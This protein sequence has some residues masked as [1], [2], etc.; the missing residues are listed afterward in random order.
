MYNIASTLGRTTK[1]RILLCADVILV[2][3]ALLAAIELQYEEG[4]APENIAQH[5]LA[6]PLLMGLGGLLTM[7]LGLHRV[8]LKAF[9][10]HAIGM[11]ALH[12]IL[13]GLATAVI[14][15]IA[16]YGTSLATFINFALLYF[17]MAF[18]TRMVMLQGLLAIYRHEQPQ[19]R[20]LIYGAGQTGRQLAA[21]L[22]TDQSTALVAFVDDNETLQ[23]TLVQGLTI[24]SPLT[25]EA[26]VKAR[27]IDRVVLAMP[28]M[29][30]AKQAQISR[31][32]RELGVDVHTVPSFAQ[33]TGQ[34]PVMQQMEPAPTDSLLGR[35]ALDDALSGDTETYA[36]KVVLISGAGGSIGS[37]LCRQV[38]SHKPSCIVLF[39]ISELALYTI[40]MELRSLR[41]N[42]KIVIV[43][44]LGSVTDADL[45]AR[46]LANCNVQIVLH[47]AAYKHVTLVEQNPIAGMSNNVLG[48]HTL[49]RAAATAQIERFILVSTDKAVRPTNIMGAS[50]RLAEMLVHDL[51]NNAKGRTIFCMVRFGNVIGSS[52]SVIPLFHEQIKLGGPVTVTHPDVTRYFMTISEAARLVLVA[53]SFDASG[54][55]FVLDMGEPVRIFDLACQMIDAV[56]Y[57]LRNEANPDG[58][59]EI[60]IIGLQPGEKI[61]EELLIGKGQTTTAHPKILQANEKHLSEIEVASA[62]RAVKDAIDRAD[63][64]ALRAVIAR[65]VEGGTDFTQSARKTPNL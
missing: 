21:A 31:R 57:S 49:A 52:G 58:D 43:P 51:A 56:G 30:H 42:K 9:E 25:L 22:R 63:E 17:F 27:K 38:A 19:C 14:D 35:P 40:D 4:I 37:E 11:T 2:A 15:D 64:P 65:W 3:P 59:I 23:T 28:S 10:S 5:W 12:A 60:K 34:A 54:D 55:V 32:L 46:T 41:R 24:Y 44:V 1:R 39:E 13:L 7:V 47:A 36:G 6:L 8:Q 33:L 18:G 61:E 53:G 50:K 62:L 45:V 16:G 48:T 26:L 20:L 29:S